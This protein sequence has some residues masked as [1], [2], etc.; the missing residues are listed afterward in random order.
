MRWDRFFEDLE[1]QLDS[2]WEAER[3][4]L[5]TESARLR[6]ARR[7]LRDRLA[8]L[9]AAQC[10]V[11][12]DVPGTRLVGALTAIGADWI[13]VQRESGLAAGAIVPLE[14]LCG[15]ALAHGDLLASARSDAVLGRMAARMSF[16]FVL[17]E[18]V[19]RRTTVTV[20]DRAGIAR[21]GTIDRAGADHLDLA[22]HEAGAP[23]R[24][25]AVTAF[26]IIPFASVA[27]VALDE[28]VQV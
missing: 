6:V 22:E 16:G 24:A 7:A 18:L 11:T 2:E 10:A 25:G 20:H 17:R 28:P 4:A 13:G 21:A 5:E 27:W 15:V 12:V 8:A 19:R 9:A 23:R 3:A 14:A 1:D 26:R